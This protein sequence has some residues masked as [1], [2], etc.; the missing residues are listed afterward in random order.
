[1]LI[2]LARR[3]AESAAAA[4]GTARANALRALGHRTLQRFDAPVLNALG[5]HQHL[6]VETPVAFVH[7]RINLLAAGAPFRLVDTLHLPELVAGDVDAR[8]RLVHVVAP[9]HLQQRDFVGRVR[10]AAL[11]R[12]A[13]DTGT[14]RV[15]TTAAR[16]RADGTA[17]C[18]PRAGMVADGGTRATDQL[19]LTEIRRLDAPAASVAGALIDR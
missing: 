17:P 18:Q 13:G 15:A 1:M 11:E 12:I 3:P 2:V 16:T 10:V 7:E 8:A 4:T 19:L 9:V 5:V 6:A 14:A